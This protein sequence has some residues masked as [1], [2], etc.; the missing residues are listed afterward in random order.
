MGLLGIPTVHVR[1]HMKARQTRSIPPLR[2]YLEKA[3]HDVEG[4]SPRQH[5]NIMENEKTRVAA[6]DWHNEPLK[7]KHSS[8]VVL[9]RS[10]DPMP[11]MTGRLG[12]WTKEMNGGSSAAYLARTPC[13]PLCCTLLNRDGN[14]MVFRLGAGGGSFPLYGGTF[15]R[16]Y[17]VSKDP[18]YRVWYALRMERSNCVFFQPPLFCQRVPAFWTQNLGKNRRISANIGS[19]QLKKWAKIR[20]KLD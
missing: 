2:C 5:G 18:N 11:N 6:W 7:R 10:K 19:N 14:R 12:Y 20:P 17:S 9:Q 13:I 1:Y 8:L 15:A 3:L 16:S 4:V